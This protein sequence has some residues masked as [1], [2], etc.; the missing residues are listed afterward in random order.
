MTIPLHLDIVLQVIAAS[1]SFVSF[2]RR[3]MLP[4]RAFAIASNVFFVAYASI[5]ALWPTAVLHAVLFPLNVKRLLDI[6]RL[7]AEVKRARAASDIAH[8]LLPHMSRRLRKAGDVLFRAGDTA[9]SMIY[10]ASGSLRIE[11]LAVELGAGELIGEIGLFAPDRKRTQTLVCAT[12]C[13]LYV[14]TDD[15]VFRLFY[16]DPSLGFYFMRLVVGRLQRDVERAAA[17]PPGGA[18]PA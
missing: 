11:G 1:L 12:D 17:R 8:L 2:T 18:L 9:D 13:E 16:Q 5:D 10:V 3:G 6:R 15:M 14:M 7:T 4:L